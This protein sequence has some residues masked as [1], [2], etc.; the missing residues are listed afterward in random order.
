MIISGAIDVMEG[1]TDVT[2]QLI[3]RIKS[4]TSE[5]FS[6]SNNSNNNSSSTGDPVS[7]LVFIPLESQQKLTT[8]DTISNSNNNGIINNNS[9][10]TPLLSS[11][12][13]S[14]HPNIN[15]TR[16]RI[17]LAH[18]ATSF[19]TRVLNDLSKRTSKSNN[20]KEIIT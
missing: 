16:Q 5:M 17:E 9:R 10:P 18:R 3:T 8:L 14:N 2:K 19:V 20:N 15:E 1:L 11:F 4:T 7:S 12:F 6:N 13:D